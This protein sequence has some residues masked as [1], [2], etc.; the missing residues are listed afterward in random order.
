MAGRMTASAQAAGRAAGRGLSMG[1]NAVVAL[2]FVVLA[3]AGQAPDG[4][5]HA[6]EAAATTAPT[7][8]ATGATG[9]AANGYDLVAF[10]IGDT[11]V[12]GE[13]DITARHAGA[14]FRFANTRNRDTFLTHPEAFMPRYGGYDALGVRQGHKLAPGAAMAWQVD[15]NRL[16]F[17]RNAETQAAWN[18]DAD[19]N[20]TVAGR[21]WA[22]IR[23]LPPALLTAAPS[24]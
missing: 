19:G 23:D 1:L 13:A 18:A 5:A 6:D 4:V 24:N 20:R 14:T 9:L 15:D 3:V 21:I 10:F 11:A 17:F 16:Y 8:I 7:A 12:R 22:E 2:A